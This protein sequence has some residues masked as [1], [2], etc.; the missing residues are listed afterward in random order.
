MK[1][2][3][4]HLSPYLPYGLS[5]LIE[6]DTIFNSNGFD[7]EFDEDPIIISGVR[8]MTGINYKNSFLND[9]VMFKEVP[10]TNKTRDGY[11]ELKDIKPILRPLSD[12]TKEIEHNGEKFIPIERL[13]NGETYCHMVY[14]E[15]V[16][17]GAEEI[18]SVPLS[19]PLAVYQKL[20]EWHFDIF[21]LIENG[22]AIDK[23]TLK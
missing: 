23:N 15:N 19:M 11:I 9:C 13:Q 6:T 2:E 16:L 14:D 17:M 22:L 21:N 18:I 8:E 10:K 1:L 20:I 7:L 4:K 3:L 5:L 12:L